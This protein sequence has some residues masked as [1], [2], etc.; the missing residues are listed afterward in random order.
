M[1]TTEHRTSLA[2]VRA[3]KVDADRAEV[4]KIAG[5]LEWLEQQVV[6]PCASADVALAGY[7]DGE[8]LLAGDGAPA[9]SEAAVV[10]LLTALGVSDAAG[11]HWLSKALEVKYRLQ[12]LWHRVLDLEVAPWRALRVAESTLSLPFAGAAFVDARLA[13]FA[14]SL[15]W[16]QLERTVEAARA[17]FDPGEAERRRAQDPRHFHVRTEGAGIDGHVYVDGL[18]DAADALDLDA[19]VSATAAQLAG[20]GCDESLDVRRAMAVGQIARAQLALDLT[21]TTG[22]GVTLYVHLSASAVATMDNTDTPVLITQ[23]ASWCAGANVTIKP[24]IDLNEARVVGGYV[25]TDPLAERVRLTWPRCVFP[26]CTRRARRCDLDHRV[27]Y[28]DG[29]TS[30]ANLAPLCRTHHRMKTFAGWTYEP[31]ATTEHG[32]PTAFTWTSPTGDHYCVDRHGSVLLEP[33]P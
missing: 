1:T 23:V 26:F 24:V 2:D 22:R 5:A 33:E 21:E 27:P 25:P 19:A 12:R 29:P 8:L 9:V 10:E 28:P 3:L 16:S 13:R 11:R 15:S 6:D 32:V 18:L 17:E 7:G 14:H 30:T 31:A 4:D 20:L